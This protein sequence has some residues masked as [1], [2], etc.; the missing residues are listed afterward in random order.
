MANFSTIRRVDAV[1]SAAKRGTPDRQTPAPPEDPEIEEGEPEEGAVSREEI[2]ALAASGGRRTIQDFISGA[3]V[4]ATPE[5]I[6]A[7]QV[8]SR[9]LVEEFGYPTEHIQTRPQFRVRV[10]PSGSQSYPVDIAVFKDAGRLPDDVLIVVECKKPTLTQGRKQ[11]EIYLTMTSAQIG[12]WFNGNAHLYLRK[13]V[14]PDQ[15]IGFEQI[16]SIPRYGQS[17]AEIGRIRRG[18]LVTPTNL[19]ATFRDIRNNLA[20]MTL[21]VTRDEALAREIINILF[22]KLWDET[23]KG[24]T[25]F[26][27]FAADIGD[28]A[29]QV[30]QRIIDIFESR[31]K[32]EFND[33]FDV[34]DAITL[35]APSV[36]YVVGELQNYAISSANREAVGDAFE[37]FIGPALRGGEGQFFTPRNV[38]QLMLT[39]LDP[40]PE[41][42]LI[43]PAC[44]SGGFLTVALEH[45]W[46]KLEQRAAARGWDQARLGRMQREYAQRYLHGIDKDSFLAKVSKAYMA[47][48]GDGR[49][50]VFC[51]NALVEPVT[52]TSALSTSTHLGSFD[53]VVTNPPFGKKIVVRGDEILR[54]YQLGRRWQPDPEGTLQPTGPLYEK[55]PPQLVFI[56]RCL[57]LLK[58]GGRLGIV[59]PESVFGMPKYRF[60]VEYI[61]RHA[62]VMAV[63]AMPEELFQ[64]YTH[65]KTCIVFL[66]KR[67]NPTDDYDILMADARWC[68]H[69]SMGNPTV[70]TNPS[71]GSTELL[72]DVPT[73]SQ[74][75]TTLLDEPTIE[76][77]DHLGF[78]VRR[79]ELANLILVPRYYDPVLKSDI[80]DLRST[81]DLVSIE[82]LVERGELSLTTGLEVGKMAYGTGPVPFVRTSDFSNW[83]LKA[84]P[85]HCVSTL[86]YSAL[87]SKQDVAPWDILLV[88][89]G[90]YLVGTSCILTPSDTRILYAG[91]LYKIRATP[92]RLDPFLLLALFNMPIVKRQFRAKRFTRDII[93]TLGKRILEVILPMPRDPEERSRLADT[94][95]EIITTRARLRELGRE[96]IGATDEPAEM[97]E[98]EGKGG[99]E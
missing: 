49:S 94:M 11:L 68:G 9:R 41:E 35:D 99:A 18:D 58:P 19:K 60:V 89:D 91:G 20:G 63:A 57:Q 87:A 42:Y 96:V 37:V 47:I 98:L 69:D 85:K 29:E 61:F 12:V 43:D 28:T 83:E 17:V 24:P 16:P 21:G 30:R 22:C 34:T 82:E 14:R 13:V 52:W 79:S 66:R 39:F 78:R 27:S 51:D 71:D 54:Q 76:R 97:W 38:V 31:V 10:R 3:D 95:R 70:R 55:Q 72:D 45:V 25:D 48:L 40:E 7:T 2:A 92:E 36:M 65:A 56:E 23:D 59:L 26:V 81:H 86:I 1:P 77:I 6:N 15:T 44:G 73:I 93:D 90:T 62:E 8:F 88:R 53:V 67:E 80:E 50:S 84:D 46:Q 74:R 75:F 4:P 64:P 5:E 32:T 33:V